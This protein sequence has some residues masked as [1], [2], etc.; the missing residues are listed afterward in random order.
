ML[1]P[2]GSVVY[3]THEDTVK[4]VNLRRARRA[5]LC[6]EDERPPFAFVVVEGKVDLIDD[7]KQVSAAAGRIGGR[8]LDIPG[9]QCVNRPGFHRGSN[10]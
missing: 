2:E 4:G 5:A 8:Y 1:G 6:V 3:K 9:L 7:L 10:P